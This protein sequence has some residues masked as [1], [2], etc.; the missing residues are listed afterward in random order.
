MLRHVPLSFLLYVLFGLNA[1]IANAAEPLASIEGELPEALK[2]LVEDVIG[3]AEIA[4]RS[5]SLTGV[6]MCF[7]P[8]SPL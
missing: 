5:L 3:E 1:Q 2:A 4:P 7:R 6:D 8:K